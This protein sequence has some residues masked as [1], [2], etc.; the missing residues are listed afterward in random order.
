MSGE[1]E[2]TA[3]RLRAHLQRAVEDVEPEPGAFARVLARTRRRRH[4]R[5]PVLSAAVTVAA[6]C[7]LLVYVLAG[8]QPEGEPHPV[9][10]RPNS[11]VA[12]AEPG[13][14][15]LY[16]IA[17]GGRGPDLARFDRSRPEALAGTA[18]NVYVLV[19][20]TQREIF[21]VSPDGQR[22]PV[23]RV[24]D[25]A[26]PSILAAR[27][28]RV[29]YVDRRAAGEAVVLVAGD[30]RRELDVPAGSSVRDVAL[31]GGGRVGVLL[32]E[33]RSTELRVV[34]PSAGAV[35]GPAVSGLDSGECGPLAVTGSESGVAVLR[36]AACGSGE[37]RV[38]KVDGASGAVTGA[39]V[40]FTAGE[41]RPGRP[42]LS[43]DRLGRVLVSAGQRQW[44]VDGAVVRDVPAQCAA[45]CAGRPA[46]LWG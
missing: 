10:V 46:T 2:S 21:A 42:Q 20:G 36:P 23:A 19:A 40:P 41:L 15:A 16:D 39:G 37:V 1:R 11:Y 8:S 28:G 12:T 18:E 33:G 43:T 6:A 3:E 27:S 45:D 24:P 31:T 38:T 7:G 17:G 25:T 34:D 4:R 14:L 13:V 44:L 26:D 5:V 35:E 32:G 22:R 9:S 29:A 30:R